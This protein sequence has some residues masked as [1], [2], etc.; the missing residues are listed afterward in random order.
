[1]EIITYIQNN[2]WNRKYNDNLLNG[3]DA[4]GITYHLEYTIN[5]SFLVMVSPDFKDA[6]LRVVLK[7]PH[8]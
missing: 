1:M 7:T 2:P 6:A 3:L 5:G 8:F 4:Q